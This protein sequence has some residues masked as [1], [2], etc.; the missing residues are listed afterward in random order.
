MNSTKFFSFILC[1][2]TTLLPRT[3]FTQKHT[4]APDFTE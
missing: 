3:N 2:T 4:P 1:A